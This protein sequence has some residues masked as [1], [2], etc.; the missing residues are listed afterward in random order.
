MKSTITKFKKALIYGAMAF[1]FFTTPNVQAQSICSGAMAYGCGNRYGY[2]GDIDAVTVKN[3]QGTV[4]ATFSGLQCNNAT[5]YRGILNQGTPFDLTAGEEITIEIT[6]TEWSGYY[7]RP[8]VWMDVDLDMSYQK[9]ECV[10]NPGSYTIGSSMQSFKVKVP[11]FNKAGSSYMRVRGCMTAYS[12]TAN[13]GCGTVNGYGNLFDLEVNYKVGATPVADFVIPTGPN[14]EG[15]AVTFSAKNPNSGATYNWNFDQA[16]NV[17][18]ATST[19]GKASWSTAGKYDV[20]MKVDY[21]G[22]AD[23]TTK[24]VTI[25][26][27][28]QAPVADF[29]ADNNEVELGYDVQ[30]FDLSTYGPTD[31]SW[32][33]FSPTGIGDDI[34]SSQNPTFTMVETGMHKVCLTSGNGYNGGSWSKTVCKDKYIECLPS[35]DNYMGPQ[36]VATTKY[37]RLFDHNGPTLDYANNRKTSIDY[38]Q[39]LPC[40]ASEIR[41]TFADLDLGD[42]GDVLTIYESDEADPNHIVATINGNNQTF[43]DTQTI[44][45]KRGAFY[46]TFE[47]NGSTVGRGFII[48]WESDLE[49]PTAPN[50]SFTMPFDTIAVG[51]EMA[52]T[53]TTSNTKGVPEYFWTRSDGAGGMYTDGFTEDYT[54]V[55]YSSATEPLCLVAKTCTGV[56]TFCKNIVINTPNTAGYVDFVANNLR[57]SIGQAV[58][59]T[60]TTDYAETF[61]WS[62]FPTTY[63]FVNG[64]DA[65]S[66]NP[67]IEFTAGGEYTFTLSARNSTSDLTCGSRCTE[68]KVIKNKYVICLDYCIPLVNLTSKDISINKVTVTDKNGGILVNRETGGDIEYNDY[69]DA[70]ALPMTYGATYDIEVSRKTS[71]NDVNYKVWIDWNIDGDFDDQGEEV[72]SSGKTSSMSV[73]G[74]FTV[75]ALSKS[76]EGTTRMRVGVSYGNFPNSPCGVNQVGEFEDYA[77]TLANDNMK[78]MINLVGDDTIRVERTSTADAC[79]EEVLGKTVTAIDATEG[80]LSQNIDITS[81]LDCQA[82][83]IYSIEFDLEDASG[84]AAETKYRTIIVVLDRTGPVLTLQ[85]NDTITIEQCG[86]FTDA[87]AVANDAV[88]GDLTSAIKVDGEVDEST[89]GDYVLTYTVKDAQG[90]ESVATRLVQVRDTEAPGIYRLGNRITDGMNIN[91]QINSAF[92]DDIYALDPCNGNIFLQKTPGYNGVV[93]N[94]ERATYPIRY[95]SSDPSG[96]KADEDGYVI[97]YIVD[98]FVAPNIELNTSDTIYHDVNDAYFSRSVTVTDNYYGPNKVSVVRSG[99][100]DP[101][102]LGTYVETF[103]ATDAS[104]NKATKMRYV[105]VVDRIAPELT[106]PPVSACVGYPF[107]AM[108]GLIMKDNYYAANDL[109]VNV[110]S[111]NINI[112]EAGVYYINYSI[113]DPSGNQAA[114]VS[115][116]VYV[117]YPPNCQNTFLGNED[118]KL[119]DAVN[120]YPNP[121]TG[122]FNVAYSL[123]NNEPLNVVVVNSVGATVA[124]TTLGGGF[125]MGELDLTHAGSGVYFV[126][127]T[128]GG[129]TTMK[130]IVVKN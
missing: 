69:T 17:I 94:Q 103:V 124:Q 71:S 119:E 29:I 22:L 97:N 42:A 56:D 65:S 63:K 32:E 78:P 60:T 125:G 100:V 44:V 102:T 77:V 8:G 25:A 86:T 28:T 21:C 114:I 4:L 107:W 11:C 113:T 36:K 87:G 121:S 64:T 68:K 115:R 41:L 67:E 109:V 129:Q 52:V 2:C 12:M 14:W 84:N 90:N 3:S 59:F 111:H 57:P 83:G 24:Q 106:A 70:R 15:S 128:N 19:R 9:D 48:N 37:G 91:V 33:I 80:D 123:N 23:S 55:S 76:F 16:D 99:K 101:Y 104:G 45:S 89:V 116:T 118:M 85:G 88:D 122:K 130:K 108:S 110:V 34:S 46:L 18:D 13:Q 72:L 7:T 47:S 10:V 27:P 117:S 92:V 39:I 26:A 105:K 82:A 66:Q 112:E 51:T 1:G 96:N 50:A 95:N 20:F 58:K 43:Y 31:W 81:D 62:I 61:A 54:F 5:T 126:R 35:L 49:T 98:D 6:G 38:F 79:W 53:N 74:S 40:G 73:S 30:L 75:P 127:M 120:V 93:N